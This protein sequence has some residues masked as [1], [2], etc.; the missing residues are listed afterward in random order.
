[1][2]HH[3]INDPDFLKDPTAILA[4]MRAE[5]ALVRIKLPIIG[6]CWSTTTDAAARDILKD[7]A[8][9]ARNPAN[10]GGPRYR[11]VLLVLTPLY[12]SLDPQHSWL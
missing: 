8:H 3:K 6:L 9:F 5:G 1:M 2:P 11:T 12:A 7:D 4:H 10:A